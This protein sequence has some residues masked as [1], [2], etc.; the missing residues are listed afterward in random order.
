MLAGFPG[1]Y[2]WLVA[3]A[4]FPGGYAWLVTLAGFPGGYARL[5]MPAGFPGGYARLVMLAGCP[6]CRLCPPA[7]LRTP[8]VMKDRPAGR[9]PGHSAPSI[10]LPSVPFC[11]PSFLLLSPTGALR[12]PRCA[13]Q[14]VG[15]LGC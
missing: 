15:E 2:A 13:R 3:L 1:G 9:H 6:A 14:E 11:C 12:T 10:D 5:V 7:E 8:A 4:R